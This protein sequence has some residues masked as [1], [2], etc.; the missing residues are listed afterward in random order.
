MNQEQPPVSGDDDDFDGIDLFW[1]GGH[2][3]AHG[4]N[5]DLRI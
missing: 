1:I 2:H 4:L 5:A 3:N